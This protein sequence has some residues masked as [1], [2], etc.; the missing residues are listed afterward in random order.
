M[1]RLF[2]RYIATTILGAIA[3]VLM[4]FVAL[5]AI[6]AIIDGMGDIKNDFTFGKLLVYIGLTLPSRIYES[7]PIASLIGCLV[8][9]GMLA[10]NSELVV[11]R[12][13]GV[14]VLRIVWFVIKPVLWLILLAALLGEYVVP[15]TDQLAESRKM[16]LKGGETAQEAA[17]GLWNREGNEF[18]HFNAVYPS[19]VLFG[20]TRYH[21]DD[22]RKIKQVS[23]SQRASYQGDYWLE[24]NGVTTDFFPT[25]TETGSFVTRKWETD[26][27]PNL[28]L[29]IMMPPDSLAIGSLSSYIDY[30][31]DQGRDSVVYELAFWKKIL[32]PLTIVS[33]VLV[34]ISFVFGPLRSATMGYRVFA[35]V[36]AGIIF[37]TIQDLLGPASI[38][39]GFSP[40]LAV[41]VPS[42]VLVFLGL[43]M[44]RRT[45]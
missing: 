11:M 26:L 14:S 43:L 44:L 32:Q 10:N 12:S 30:L 7:L 15:R 31:N 35:G 3:M 22:Q 40:L 1:M 34:A 41:L 19:G 5:D 17:G 18:M 24:E 45:G 13:S 39:F 42:L 4:V 25:R 16:L 2:S 33:L 36:V 37:R 20:V 6:G 8:G 29:L 21:F 27:A 23:F 9:L 28:L 38:V